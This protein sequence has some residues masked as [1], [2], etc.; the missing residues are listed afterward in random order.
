[1]TNVANG[2]ATFIV[3]G[4]FTQSTGDTRILYNVT[5]TNSGIF[6][7]TFNKLN[8]NG[9]IFMA[10]TA[11]R[12]SGGV[13]TFNVTNDFNVN[14]SSPADKFRVTSISSINS[15]MNNVEVNFNVGGNLHLNGHAMSEF[16]STASAGKETVT[17]HG[18]LIVDGTDASFN[19][20]TTQASHDNTL[21]IDGNLAVNNGSVY[22]SRNNGTASINTGGN[23]TINAGTL[24]LKGGTGIAVFTLT[25][26]YTQSGGTFNIHNNSTTPTPST[27]TMNVSGSFTQT[28]GV[29]SFDNNSSYQS[30]TH[31]LN[32]KGS[33]YNISGGTM[34]H[35]GAGSCLIFGQLNFAAVGSMQ[36]NRTGNGHL[37]T[38]V[39]QNVKERCILIAQSGNIQ[40]ASHQ[41]PETNYFRIEPNGRL[42]LK[43]QSQIFSNGLFA[44]TGIQIDSAGEIAIQHT[45]GMYNGSPNSAFNAVYNMNYFLHQS[46][47]VEYNGFLPQLVTGIGVGTATGEQ[48]KYGILKINFSGGVPKSVSLALAN[49]CVRTQL[50]LIKGELNLNSQTL[51][52]ENGNT[53]AIIRTTGYIRSE[54]TV[55]GFICW[56]NITSGAHIFPFGVSP[57][58]FI[59]VTL[60]PVSG[61]GNDITLGTYSVQADNRPYPLLGPTPI[62]FRTEEYPSTDVIDRW[63]IWRGMGITADVTL[64][65]L[66]NERATLADGNAQLGISRWNGTGWTLS[67]GTAGATGT[68]S[69]K[70][71]PTV[72]PWIICPK[73]ISVSYQLASFN[74]EQIDDMVSLKWTTASEFNS[75]IF[76]VERSTDGIDFETIGTVKAF[77]TSTSPLNYSY[78]DREPV[79]ETAYYRIK[80]LDLSGKPVSS[81]IRKVVF[82][83]VTPVNI[84][85]ENFGP[86]PF[87]NSFQVTYR[88]T[89]EGLVRFQLSNVKGEILHSSETNDEK[90]SHRFDYTD[91][92]TLMPG[93]YF[94]KM[95]YGDKVITQKLIKK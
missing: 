1:M 77:G 67:A 84:T 39:K 72:S 69:I 2:N 26:N 28:G 68:V 73:G 55:C 23:L 52:L 4:T 92:N 9:G 81:E 16:T 79:R 32:I 88:T 95:M 91:G 85:I 34:T 83:N 58:G 48:H 6:T 42:E 31:S 47:I 3:D 76:Q 62:S 14:F 45:A 43:S 53:N 41:T 27:N 87:D 36:F 90:G 5:T 25:N 46:S 75:D 64:T 21:T 51:T 63:W 13:C 54:L 18:D 94:L 49:I 33:S 86:N 59:P 60:S 50:Q 57:S 70:N 61:L 24:S 15:S 80:Q 29:F 71:V 17:I 44:N 11:C 56:K 66:T 82:D 78:I 40:L 30:A 35:A 65:Y 10:Q 37:I 8:L 22:L 20:G 89:K 12:T 38:Q 93:I 7:A 19:Y 74:A